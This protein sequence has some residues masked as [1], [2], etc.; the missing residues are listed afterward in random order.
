MWD[1]GSAVFCRITHQVVTLLW[2]QGSEIWVQ[3]NRTTDDK[4]H[5]VMTLLLG[6]LLILVVLV[7]MLKRTIFLVT[8]AL[9]LHKWKPKNEVGPP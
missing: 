6:G 2:N 5:L 3:Q 9:I 4:M 7:I 1:Q 8:I